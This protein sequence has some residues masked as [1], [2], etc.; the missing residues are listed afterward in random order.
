MDGSRLPEGGTL[1]RH[2]P[3]PKKGLKIPDPLHSRRAHAPILGV[4]AFGLQTPQRLAVHHKFLDRG[5]DQ[6]LPPAPS[7]PPR[8]QIHHREKSLQP[9]PRNHKFPKHE[10]NPP[11]NN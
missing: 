3:S 6:I 4:Q 7:H 5:R 9:L 1:R 11:I 8:L 10:P 2:D